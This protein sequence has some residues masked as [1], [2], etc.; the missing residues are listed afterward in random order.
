[1]FNSARSWDRVL[2]AYG[3]NGD[4]TQFTYCR[5][6]APDSASLGGYYCGTE[7]SKSDV[8][9]YSTAWG[10]N[11]VVQYQRDITMDSFPGDSGAPVFAWYNGGVAAVGQFV[12]CHSAASTYC[13]TN[14]G[15]FSSIFDVTSNL[16]ASV[17]TSTLN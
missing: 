4:Q 14:I 13:T 6:G 12:G 1:M 16:G 3:W 11:V 2:A 8:V 15:Y 5:S 17:V 9:G 7:T 10:A